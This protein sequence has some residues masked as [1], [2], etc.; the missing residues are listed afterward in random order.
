[1]YPL[2]NL[3]SNELTQENAETGGEAFC[4]GTENVARGAEQKGENKGS[5]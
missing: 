1:M 2:N 4:V 5:L 3:Q